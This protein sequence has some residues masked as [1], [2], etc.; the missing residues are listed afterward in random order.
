MLL[1]ALLLPLGAG[2]TRAGR[3][4]PRW[5]WPFLAAA[6][7][8]AT[9]F[10]FVA[11]AQARALGTLNGYTAGVCALTWAFAIA[12]VVTALQAATRPMPPFARLYR[13]LLGAAACVATIFLAAHGIVGVRLWSW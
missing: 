4:S 3:A 11:G 5:G 1:T 10:V 6:S 7:F 9:P 13:L 2:L 12:S 8:V